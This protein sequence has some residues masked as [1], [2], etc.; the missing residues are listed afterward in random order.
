MQIPQHVE[1]LLMEYFITVK[2]VVAFLYRL[3]YMIWFRDSLFQYTVAVI[4][5]A[6]LGVL[7]LLSFPLTGS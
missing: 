7:F 3:C 2:V 6:N 4:S 5:R 1:Y